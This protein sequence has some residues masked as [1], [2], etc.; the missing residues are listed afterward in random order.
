MNLLRYKVEAFEHKMG[1]VIQRLSQLINGQPLDKALTQSTD[2][3][4][5]IKKIEEEQKKQEMSVVNSNG[6]GS[7]GNRELTDKV[8]RIY[9][10]LDDI[11]LA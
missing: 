3:I 11:A 6:S 2:E 9:H 5:Q 1:I 8:Q 10:N 4:A 7:V